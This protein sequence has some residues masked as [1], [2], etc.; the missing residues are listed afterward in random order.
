MTCLLGQGLGK[1]RAGRETARG[2]APYPQALGATAPGSPALSRVWG[3]HPSGSW[4]S[5]APPLGSPAAGRPCC[6]GGTAPAASPG[7]PCTGRSVAPCPGT[8]V[9]GAQGAPGPRGT[10]PPRTGRPGPRGG[11]PEGVPAGEGSSCSQA[12]PL[13]GREQGPGLCC[14]QLGRVDS[15]LKPGSGPGGLGGWEGQGA[16]RGHAINS[17]S[18]GHK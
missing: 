14:W 18:I 4:S 9:A 6:V 13:S 3:P 1:P 16:H 8:A 7:L 5:E 15:G 10:R 11:T 12:W 17:P 2:P